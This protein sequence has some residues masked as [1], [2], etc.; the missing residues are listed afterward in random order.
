MR[1]S[2]AGSA[3]Q[4]QIGAFANPAVAGAKRQ[5]M[6]LRDHRHR[7]E[8]EAVEGF[9]R[10]QL[11]LDEMAREP[12]AVPFGDLVLGEHGQEAGG[13]PAFFIRSLGEGSPVLFDRGQAKFVEDQGEPA[14]V[15]ALGHDRTPSSSLSKASYELSG[16]RCTTTSGSAAGSGA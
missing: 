14:T 10:Q 11:R 12:A 6:G 3:D 16:A 9:S 1:F 5:D 4:Q 7:V 8:V 2:S 13:W 15:D